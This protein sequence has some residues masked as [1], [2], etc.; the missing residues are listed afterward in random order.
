MCVEAPRYVAHLEAFTAVPSV[1]LHYCGSAA[2]S[3]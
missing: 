3:T 1:V 2:A